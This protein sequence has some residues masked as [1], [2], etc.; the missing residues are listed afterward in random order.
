MERATTVIDLPSGPVEYRLEERG[1]RVVL[2]L[3]GGHMRAGLP[4][5]EETF[6]DAGCTV[7]AVSRPGYGRTL[8]PPAPHPISSPL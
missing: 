5:G 3:H 7:L 6:A 8:W 4:L 2:M 1:P